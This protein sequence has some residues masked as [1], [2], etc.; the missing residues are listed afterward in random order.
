MNAGRTG[1]A[2]W[3]QDVQIMIDSTV[4]L[5][6]MGTAGKSGKTTINK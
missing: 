2:G 4:Y 6:D 1:P 3:L 5:T